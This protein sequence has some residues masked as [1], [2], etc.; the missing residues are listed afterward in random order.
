MSDSE[1]TTNDATSNS[2]QHTVNT[3]RDHIWHQEHFWHH[4]SEEYVLNT[5]HKETSSGGHS[6][7]IDN[8]NTKVCSF[9]LK[10]PMM[11]QRVVLLRLKQVGAHVIVTEIDPMCAL[12]ALI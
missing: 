1:R 12:Q 4:R 3:L 7:E 8:L 9:F 6:S 10:L 2:S 11:L 5:S